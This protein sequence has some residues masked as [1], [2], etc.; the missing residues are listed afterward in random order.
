MTE[1]EK[2]RLRKAIGYH[3]LGNERDKMML[4]DLFP[5]LQDT[6]KTREMLI[7]AVRHYFS[8]SPYS[9]DISKELALAWIKKIDGLPEEEFN[10]TDMEEARKNL[11]SLCYDWENGKKTTLLPIAAVRARY[12]LK[13]YIGRVSHWKPSLNQMEMFLKAICF[14][15]DHG[16]KD[17]GGALES[18]YKDLKML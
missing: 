6:A 2:Q 1:Y 9:D 16:F 18:L 5:E 8:P 7:D 11:L 10:D 4:E 3:F 12:F 14:L 13:Q 17:P 15:G